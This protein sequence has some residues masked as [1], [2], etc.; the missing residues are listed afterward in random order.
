M[1]YSL[2]SYVLGL[3]FM[4]VATSGYF[5][6][7]TVF[8]AE[9]RPQTSLGAESRPRTLQRPLTSDEEQYVR[10][11]YFPSYYNPKTVRGIMAKY[12]DKF[13][14]GVKKMWEFDV[15]YQKRTD[16]PD[17]HANK[18]NPA[19]LES[20][21]D[22]NSSDSSK[23]KNKTPVVQ[24]SIDDNLSPNTQQSSDDSAT[25]PGICPPG[26]VLCGRVYL[27][28]GTYIEQPESV[29]VQHENGGGFYLTPALGGKPISQE[30]IDFARSAARNGYR[31]RGLS[32]AA[33]DQG[34]DLARRR[35]KETPVKNGRK[36]RLE[37]DMKTGKHRIIYDGR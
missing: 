28:D 26:E 15:N 18:D 10:I 20:R 2:R 8:G 4:V 9:P 29:K 35:L 11:G 16:T 14:D 34:A 32:Q 7:S 33:I 12:P 37:L 25:P 5:S 30:S 17:T 3:A 1:K 13:S 27:K 6:P 21:M 22:S 31:Q 19:N 24:E 36:G 23:V